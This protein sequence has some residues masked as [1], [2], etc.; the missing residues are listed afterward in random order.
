MD[1]LDQFVISL[2]DWLARIVRSNMLF[3]ILVAAVVAVLI[4]AAWWNL[5]N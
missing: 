2:L 4:A 1:M 3:G 5:S